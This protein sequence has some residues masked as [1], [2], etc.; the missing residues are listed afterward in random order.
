M[1]AVWMMVAFRN[2]SSIVNWHFG[3]RTNSHPHLRYKH[4]CVRDIGCRHRH[5][6]LGANLFFLTM[7]RQHSQYDSRLG[8]SF[9]VLVR[10]RLGLGL[11]LVLWL[12]LGLA[13]LE[14]DGGTAA[15]CRRALPTGRNA[16]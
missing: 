11:E 12:W 16:S 13:G 7:L 15:I 2:T 6:V 3:R 10:V 4:V 1:S 8:F 5:Y 14:F 9:R